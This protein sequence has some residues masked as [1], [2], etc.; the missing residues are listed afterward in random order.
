MSIFEALMLICFGA[1][2]PPSIYKS[3][4]SK[5]TSGK[6]LTF[7]IIVMLG[8]ICGILNKIFYHFDYVIFLYILNLIMVFADSCIYLRNKKLEKATSSKTESI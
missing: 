6:S 5:S 8:Y 7:L 2:W 4:T 1:A 3:L